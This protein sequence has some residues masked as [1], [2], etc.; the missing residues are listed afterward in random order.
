MR[1]AVAYKAYQLYQNGREHICGFG[2]C[3]SLEE[4]RSKWAKGVKVVEITDAEL[5]ELR[6]QAEIPQYDDAWER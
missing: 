2:Y 6:K 5:A 4:A 3:A 1:E